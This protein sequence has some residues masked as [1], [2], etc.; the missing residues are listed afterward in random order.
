MIKHIFKILWNERKQNVVILLELLVIS[1]ILWSVVDKMYCRTRNYLS[2]TGFDIENTYLVQIKEIPP[3]NEEYVEGFDSTQKT[4]A[5]LEISRRIKHF[6][7]VE[8]SSLSLASR[9]G[10]PGNITPVAF[11]GGS[12][13]HIGFLFKFVS[14]EFVD[15]Y[16]YQPSDGDR[17]KMRRVLED[18]ELLIS[19]DFEEKL[20]SVNGNNSILGDTLF[21]D[22]ELQSP[23]GVVGGLVKPI[24]YSKYQSANSVLVRKITAGEIEQFVDWIQGWEF[25]IRVRPEAMADFEE[26]F[27]R[28]LAP[29]M[30]I[31]NY[32]F[33][34]ILYNPDQF[35]FEARS[36]RNVFLSESILLI[37]L[38]ANILLGVAGVFWYRT[39]QRRSQIGLRISFGSTPR[40]A[41]GFF[42]LEGVLILS[43][44]MVGAAI[45]M[46]IVFQQDI[47]SVELIPID[48][49][50]YIGG[51]L[52]TMIVM[53]GPV[54]LAVW[55][56]T[57]KTKRIPPAEALR[58]E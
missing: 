28:E 44:A 20:R 30:E 43:I 47:L 3:L 50:R 24:R 8:T 15:V 9:P 17:A 16:R 42:L 39:A 53:L 41:Q 13:D 18:G 35:E 55:M 27:K 19:E 4:E 38:V 21:F 32:R 57:R 31:G 1:L 7:G 2:P 46:A 37:F 5:I 29:M 12:K 49:R 56:P 10:S 45:V 6:P 11:T 40:G 23:M 34:H 58:E 26:R 51:L 33:Q 52:I 54:L 14:P 25:S 36:M 48:L 22:A